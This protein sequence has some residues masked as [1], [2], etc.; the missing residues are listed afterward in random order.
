M[1]AIVLF[2]F[3]VLH[4]HRGIASYNVDSNSKLYFTLPFT[5]VIII[6]PFSILLYFILTKE[7][8]SCRHYQS[9]SVCMFRES[10]NICVLL[11]IGLVTQSVSSWMSFESFFSLIFEKYY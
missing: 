8:C 4:S 1:F 11:V 5:I 3:N 7:A 2:F 6:V 10:S 9:F